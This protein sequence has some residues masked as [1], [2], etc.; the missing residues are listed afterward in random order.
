D[1]AESLANA[2]DPAA[3]VHVRLDL[4][5]KVLRVATTTVDTEVVKSEFEKMTATLTTV[6]G[7]T[8][9]K[10]TEAAETL[11]DDESGTLPVALSG[12]REEL[13]D[14]LGNV[15]DEDSKSSVIAK[16]EDVHRRAA[17]AQLDQFKRLINPDAPDSPLGAWRRD[18][19]RAVN[20]K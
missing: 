11:L 18:I 10:I 4:G 16:L 8:I 2:D 9:D 14:L 6:T 12:F 1:V 7:E 20:E 19:V 3:A 15:F 17:E 13:E 5:D